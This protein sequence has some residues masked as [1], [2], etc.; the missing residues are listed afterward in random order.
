[1]IRMEVLGLPQAPIAGGTRM[2]RR[3]RAVLEALANRATT[4][5][6]RFVDDNGPKGGVATRCALTVKVPGRPPLHVEE[7]ETTPG[8]AF[9]AAL[10]KLTRALRRA[11][12]AR[13][14]AGRYP[15]KYYAAR[16]A[17]G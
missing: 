8:R 4:A 16:Q 9:D 10:V 11:A 3:L 15:K 1:M 13:R 17:Q 2:T 12:G 6:V 14:D 5:R 7:T